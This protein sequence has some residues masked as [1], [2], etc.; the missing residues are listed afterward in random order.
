MSPT[1]TTSANDM[2]TSGQAKSGNHGYRIH[3]KKLSLTEDFKTTAEDLYYTLT[4]I[5]VG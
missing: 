2:K 1:T 4:N 5:E 3:T